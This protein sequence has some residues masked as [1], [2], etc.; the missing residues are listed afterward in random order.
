MAPQ[1]RR[2]PRCRYE[3]AE[4]PRILSR[5]GNVIAA[6]FRPKPEF[7]ITFT[8]RSEILF[9]DDAVMLTRTTAY[10]GDEPLMVLHF[11]GD[12]K[13]GRVTQI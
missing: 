12:L 9:R 3:R 2:L 1:S 4:M 11:A 8:V 13:T 10:C 7:T 5:H 6:D